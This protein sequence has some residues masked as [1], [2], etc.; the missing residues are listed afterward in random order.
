MGLSSVPEKKL[1]EDASVTRL[2]GCEAPRI[3]SAEKT[4]RHAML[5]E[6]CCPRG[7]AEPS[8]ATGAA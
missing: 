4:T 2:L 5:F 3:N 6:G 8:D 7:G 1:V